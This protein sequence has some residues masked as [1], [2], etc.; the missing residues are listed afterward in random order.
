MEQ[1]SYYITAAAFA[2]IIIC[3]FVF[4]GTFFLRKKPD[5][6]KDSVRAPKSFI[7]IALQGVAFGLVWAL[8]RT[9]FL[10]PLIDSQY[11][12]NIFFQILAISLAVGAVWMANSAIRTLG[13]QW[14]FQARLI[15]DHKLVTGGVYQ[16]VRHP[17][18]AAMLGKLL[19]T[20]IILS[21]WLVLI[22][23]VAVFFIGTKIRTVAEE[24]LLRDAFPEEYDEYAEKVPAFIPF[25]KI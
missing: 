18:Y 15:E 24:K 16:I 6:G 4:A 9:P 14:S 12:L 17:I 25:V 21:H 11:A 5:A 2:I 23:A 19:A 7:G 10:S 20:G 1:I 13:K 22:I 8:H 3:W